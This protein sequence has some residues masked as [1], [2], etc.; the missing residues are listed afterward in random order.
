MY[1]LEDYLYFRGDLGFDVSPVNEIDEMVFSI[2][3]KADFTGILGENEIK[4]YSEVFDRFFESKDCNENLRFGLLASKKLMKTM[5]DISRCRRFAGIKICNFV[6]RV[7]TEI[8]EQMSA[9][10]V[11]G[12]DD[13]IYVT[14]RGTDDTLIGWKE[15]CEL[16]IMDS[17]P[18]QRDAAAYLE[19]IAEVFRG[20]LRVTGHSKGGNLAVY[21]AAHADARTQEKI[22]KIISYD[23][24]GF[25]KE[26]FETAGY[27]VIKNRTVT[28]V[29]KASIV[30]MMMENAGMMDVIDC[31]SEGVAAHDVLTW[32][33][34][35]KRFL[36]AQEL[37]EKSVVFR[38]ALEKT[39]DKMDIGERQEMVDE[40]FTVL[41]S[42]GADELLDFT[43]N[44]FAQALTLSKNFRKS[45]E[46]KEFISD[47]SRF[48]IR[49]SAKNTI[50]DLHEKIHDKVI[51]PVKDRIGELKDPES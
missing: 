31:E 13:R 29:P 19:S 42:T 51:D 8:T 4:E 23:G 28:M 44:T 21:A 1:T 34:S 43:E 18:A 46:L 45:K 10:T 39:L 35:Q 33:I 38:G 14:F 50:S 41:S 15:N 20:P 7:S 25:P 22:E 48:F 24:P 37:S 17:V 27:Y 47:L 6:K 49:D 11:L 26:F 5:L 40:L 12:P 16:A 3:G 32:G 9:L 30:G 2:I 36:R